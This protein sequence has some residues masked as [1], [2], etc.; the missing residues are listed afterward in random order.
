MIFKQMYKKGEETMTVILCADDRGG[1]CFAGRR[2]SQDRYVR[3]DILALCKTK[4]LFMDH[5]SKGQFTEPE[6]AVIE[7]ADDFLDVL[8][9]ED[10]CFLERQTPQ[11][12]LERASQLIVYRWNRHYPSTHS[13]K[14]PPDGWIQTWGEE[15]CGYSHETITREVYEREA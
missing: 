15:F 12:Y 3:N 14:L 2:Q 11:P 9:E 1:L 4:R 5:Y 10:V 13:I 7:V 6:G 8:G